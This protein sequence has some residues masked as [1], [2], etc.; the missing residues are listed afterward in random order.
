MIPATVKCAARMN[1]RNK[2]RSP[3]PSSAAQRLATME[4][5]CRQASR[6]IWAM[7]QQVHSS[8]VWRLPPEK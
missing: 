1:H 3:A 8:D 6:L 7:L 5:Q 4:T 2:S